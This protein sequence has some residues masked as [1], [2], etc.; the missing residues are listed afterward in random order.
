MS[1]I[2]HYGKYNGNS[3]CRCLVETNKHAE[4]YV[5]FYYVKLFSVADKYQV[6]FNTQPFRQAQCVDKPT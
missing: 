3:Q 1:K 4:L 2:E 5:C 6:G